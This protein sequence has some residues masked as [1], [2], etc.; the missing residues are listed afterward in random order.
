MLWWKTSEM[1][2]SYGVELLITMGTEQNPHV[3]TENVIYNEVHRKNNNDNE[4][5]STW[6]YK[7]EQDQLQD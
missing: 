3:K 4:I 1:S 7:Q 5:I 2:K 6:K